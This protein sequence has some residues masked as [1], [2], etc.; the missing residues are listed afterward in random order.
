M[1]EKDFEVYIQQIADDLEIEKSAAVDKYDPK[2]FFV[3]EKP[4]TAAKE[5]TSAETETVAEE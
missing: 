3:A 2:M 1:K 5:T 4:T